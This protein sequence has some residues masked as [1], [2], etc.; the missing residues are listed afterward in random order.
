MVALS[1]AVEAQMLDGVAFSARFFMGQ[2]QVDK[3]LLQFAERLD[4][5]QIP[6]AIIGAMALNAYG[7]RRVTEDVDVL[8]TADGLARFKARYLGPRL[9]PRQRRAT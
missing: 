2:S 6:Y 7:Y 1:P 9:S 3:A 4:A 8:L 5:E